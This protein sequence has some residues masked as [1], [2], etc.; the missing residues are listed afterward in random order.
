MEQK[1][2]KISVLNNE[3]D[4]FSNKQINLIRYYQH[5]FVPSEHFIG[6]KK[7]H[8]EKYRPVRTFDKLYV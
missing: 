6:R 5:Q 1:S 8:R 2:I 7:M 4:L 3:I